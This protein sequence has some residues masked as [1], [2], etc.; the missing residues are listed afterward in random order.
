MRIFSTLNSDYHVDEDTCVGVKCRHSEAWI[1]D[2]MAVGRNLSGGLIRTSFGYTP[3]RPGPGASLWFDAGGM[4]IVTST[5][6]AIGS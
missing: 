3:A 6:T 4:D 1:K 2:H 5:V